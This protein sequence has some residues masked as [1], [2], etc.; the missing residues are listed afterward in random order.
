MFEKLNKRIR[1]F[2]NKK[3]EPYFSLYQILGFYPDNIQL[4][5]QAFLHKSASIENSDGRW[6][7]NERLEFL[8]DA[9]LNAIV[10]DIVYKHFQYKREGFLTNTRSKIVQRET[11]NRI[12]FEL[13]LD[14]KIIYS[15]KLNPHNNHVYGDALEALIGAIYL[16]Q[17]Y[18]VCYKFIQDVIIKKH[19]FN[20]I[21]RHSINQILCNRN[22]EIIIKFNIKLF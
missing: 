1:L 19:I 17:G 4:Y 9:L 16:D 7:N 18:H 2:K 5:E 3:K 15:A 22:I 13:G 21:N 20:A 10:A 11:M 8:G 14:K 6:V 12:A